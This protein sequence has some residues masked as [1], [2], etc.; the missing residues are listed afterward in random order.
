M[1]FSE[2]DFWSRRGQGAEAAGPGRAMPRRR[3]AIQHSRAF[4][5]G[6]NG[7][8]CLE[9]VAADGGAGVLATLRED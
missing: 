4:L 3:V 7:Y 6:R 8:P 2:T 1:T 9:F 5:R